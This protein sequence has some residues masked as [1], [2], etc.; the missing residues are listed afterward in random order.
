MKP[1]T[2]WALLVLAVVAIGILWVLWSQRNQPQAPPDS[3]VA[4]QPVTLD[5]QD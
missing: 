1:A 4:K 5:W 3:G 2:R